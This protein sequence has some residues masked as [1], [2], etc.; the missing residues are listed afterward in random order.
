MEKKKL[1]IADDEE[2]VRYLLTGALQSELYEIDTVEDGEKAIQQMEMKSYDLIITDYMMPQMDGLE[3][4]K[5]IN[6][7]YP[8]LPVI[9]ITACGPENNFIDSG[10]TACFIKPFDISDLKSL[11]KKLLNTER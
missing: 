4:T 8:F 7:K 3:L 6:E 5:R 1:L 9:L 10:I 2:A 11:I